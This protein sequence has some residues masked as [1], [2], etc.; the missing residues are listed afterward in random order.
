VRLE[1]TDAA[2]RLHT[3]HLELPSAYPQAALSARADLPALVAA[4]GGGV[5]AAVGG[6]APGGVAWSGQGGVAAY[7]QFQQVRQN[8][9]GRGM[10][11]WWR[12]R[13]RGPNPLR[14]QVC[15]ARNVGAHPTRAR[16]MPGFA[17]YELGCAGLSHLASRFTV[18]LVGIM[19]HTSVVTGPPCL[20]R[21]CTS[22]RT[23]GTAW[24]RWTRM[25]A[26]WSLQP[27]P[28]LPLPGPSRSSRGSRSRSQP[29]WCGGAAAARTDGWRC[30]A[31]A[32]SP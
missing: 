21:R 5:G 24:R 4:S 26:C 1:L 30:R 29:A 10:G 27:P 16:T 7:E 9:R 2:Q 12:G 18:F 3:L 11:L 20:R 22:T 17:V 19:Q 8:G 14:T 23:C 28:L 6:G 25:R 32:A 15:E 31:T 13:G